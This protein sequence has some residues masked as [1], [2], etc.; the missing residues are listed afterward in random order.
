VV[1]ASIPVNDWGSAELSDSDNQRTFETSPPIQILNQCGQ[2]AIHSGQ[3][4]LSVLDKIVCMS[5]PIL[6]LLFEVVDVNEGDS[7]FD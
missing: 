6:T 1:P 5:I 3:E 4:M 2:S 7:G